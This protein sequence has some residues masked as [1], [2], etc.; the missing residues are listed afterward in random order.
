METLY[1]E[2]FFNFFF[3]YKHLKSWGN[4]RMVCLYF[5]CVQLILLFMSR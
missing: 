5:R 3:A 1:F 2:V 4:T